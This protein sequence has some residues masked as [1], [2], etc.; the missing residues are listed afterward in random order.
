[1]ESVSF[2]KRHERPAG[3]TVATNEAV[4]LFGSEFHD[5]GI[6]PPWPSSLIEAD[7]ISSQPV[8]YFPVIPPSTG[9]VTAVM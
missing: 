3:A 6:W 8:R 9:N 2:V 1:M 4:T 5:S 7:D